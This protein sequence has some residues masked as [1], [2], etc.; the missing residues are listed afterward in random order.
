RSPGKDKMAQAEVM[1]VTQHQ[2][3]GKPGDPCVMVIFGA[4]G[5]LTRH[6]LIPALYNLAKNELLSREF[7][8]LGVARAKKNT[9]E[10]RKKV[11]DDL[12]EFATGSVDPDLREWLVGRMHNLQGNF[13]DKN[14]YSKFN[15]FMQKVERVQAKHGNFFF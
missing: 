5:D 1:P 3:I 9:E 10:F 4:A 15:A 7:S 2:R 13:K 8:V 11:A 12:T 14:L 6:K